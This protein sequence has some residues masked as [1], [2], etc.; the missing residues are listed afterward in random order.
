MCGLPA[1][2]ALG[3]EAKDEKHKFEGTYGKE[4]NHKQIIVKEYHNFSELIK[5]QRKNMSDEEV[6]DLLK[7]YSSEVGVR[8]GKSQA[9]NSSDN[10]FE[11]FV[12][13]F[14]PLAYKNRLTLEIV[15]DSP[16]VFELKVT[17]YIW[18]TV[19]KE[20]DL[21]GEIGHAAIC[22]IDY[23]WPKAFNPDFK[24]ERTKTIMQGYDH[25]NHKYINTK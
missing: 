8:V 21:A 23:S 16:Q 7:K 15:K 9:E 24:M 12:K 11:S 3:V 20:F 2:S 5:I 25:C 1:L 19:F 13:N 6:L 22:N 17:E 4:L 10:T 18:A 14:K